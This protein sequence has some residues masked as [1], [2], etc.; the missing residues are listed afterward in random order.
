MA[1]SALYNSISQHTESHVKVY[2]KSASLKGGWRFIILFL[3]GY[4]VMAS[5]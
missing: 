4:T 2:I 5:K 3:Y 1:F